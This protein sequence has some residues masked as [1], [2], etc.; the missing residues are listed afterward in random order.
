MSRLAGRALVVLSSCLLVLALVAGYVERA[1]FDS[2]QFANRATEALRDDSVRSLIAQRITDEV[3]LAQQ[4][5]LLAARPIIQSV[6]ADLVGSSVFAG[7]FRS[8]VRDVHR[9]VVDRGQDTFTLT[10]RDV[11]TVLAEG[12]EQLR[13]GVAK[14]VRATERVEVVSSDLG[15]VGSDL[16]ELADRARLLAIVLLV[17]WVVVTAGAVALARDRRRTAVELGV[18]AA[19]GGVVVVIALGVLRSVALD[20]VDGPEERAAAGAV[21]DAFLGDRRIAGWILVGCGAVVAAAAS[22]YL[23]PAPLGAPLRSAAA[24]IA[25][26]PERPLLRWLRGIG[27]IAAGVITLVERDAVVALVF[28]LAAA[29]LVY[30]GVA[31]ILRLL[32]RPPEPGADPRARPRPVRRLA[33]AAVGGVVVVGAVGAFVGGGGTTVAAPPTGACNGHR[34]LCD[35]PIDELVLP[36]TH[37]A[38]SVPLPGW[39]AA[40]QDAPIADQL[41]DGVRGLLIDTHY[42]D[43]LPDR[44]VRTVFVD[45]SKPQQAVAEDGVSQA[46]LDAGLRIRDRIVGSGKGERGLY[47]CHTLCELGATPLEPVLRDLHDFLVANPDEFVVAVNE[48]Y[49]SPEDFTE[50]VEDAGLGDLVYRGPVDG[51]WPT[52]REALDQGWRVLFLAE[53]VAGARPWYHPA[54]DSIVEDTPYTFRS[55]AALTDPDGLAKTCEPNRGPERAPLFLVNHWVSTDPTP[56]PSDATKVNAREPLLRRM[57]ECERVRDHLPGLVAVNFYRRGDLFGVVDELNGVR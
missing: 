35:R 27:L 34:Q 14:D 1:A 28:T 10:V 52:L 21:W 54:F 25:R 33:P 18:G 16:A 38:M 29:Y 8:A 43:R 2:D 39:F 57:R 13:P 45:R 31:A 24:A 55:A 49:V 23:K 4:E 3:V 11:G 19:V 9:T 12:L 53:S 40:E 22:S 26:E 32:Y 15:S 20:S 17:L 6:T 37:N 36:A 44:R 48:D 50:A 41:E 47:L 5:D 56:R 7:L 42:G 30:E 46:T 51:E